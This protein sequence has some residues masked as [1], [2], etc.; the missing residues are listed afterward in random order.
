[1]LSAAVAAGIGPPILNFRRGLFDTVSVC[2]RPE[3]PR[4]PRWFAL[5]LLLAPLTLPAARAQAAEPDLRLAMMPHGGGPVGPRA[6]PLGDDPG[7]PDDAVRTSG[8]PADHPPGGP[9]GEVWHVFR[10]A[11]HG[12]S[13]PISADYDY[14]GEVFSNTR[15]GVSTTG[16]TGYDGLFDLTLKADLQKT[17]FPLGGA[18]LLLA[19]E[20]HGGFNIQSDIGELQHLS[21]IIATDFM[22]VSEYWWDRQLGGGML[23]IRLGKQDANRLFSVVEMGSLFVRA[24]FQYPAVIPIPSY[25]DQAMGAAVNL[26]PGE[27]LSL[28]AGVWDGRPFGGNWGFSG[29]GVTFSIYEARLRYRLFGRLPGDCNAGLWY[30]SDRFNAVATGS[31]AVFAGNYG[32]YVNAEQWLWLERHEKEDKSESDEGAKPGLTDPAGQAADQ[33]GL[34]VFCQYFRAPADRNE[35]HQYVGGGLVYRGLLPGRDQDIIAAGAGHLIFSPYLP[36]R[37]PETAVELFYKAQVKRGLSLQPDVQ[38]ITRPG[39]VYPDALV[40]GMRF[41]MDL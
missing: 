24:S 39:G 36:A 7:D 29:S 20:H 40:V 22:R 27:R 13:G 25:P 4:M 1:M 3:G 6:P 14:Y 41:E 19:E 17:A 37:K 32:P 34:G 30:N 10:R 33:Q 35:A 23:Q 18:L 26:N 16:A 11:V 38:I 2:R 12:G 31:E 28:G 8:A 21:N 15:G 9:P 5:P